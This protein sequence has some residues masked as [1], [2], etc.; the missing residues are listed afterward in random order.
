MTT[1][2]N[3]LQIFD[4]PFALGATRSNTVGPADSM[5]TI[6][7]LLYREGFTSFRMGYASS[8]AW[9]LTVMILLI[10]FV[11]FRMSNRWVNYE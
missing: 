4:V 11:Q 2:I 10:T 3:C 8:I 1:L 6:V 9:V 7:P 5:L